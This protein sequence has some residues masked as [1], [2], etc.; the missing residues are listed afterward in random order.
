VY[1]E[2]SQITEDNLLKTV[3]ELSFDLETL[4][5]IRVD[6]DDF[7]RNPTEHKYLKICRK[8]GQMTTKISF[9]GK[10]LDNTIA[11]TIGILEEAIWRYCQ[12]YTIHL[13]EGTGPDKHRYLNDVDMMSSCWSADDEPSREIQIVDCTRDRSQAGTVLDPDYSNAT[14]RGKYHSLE[15]MF[16]R[17]RPEIVAQV[18][19]HNISGR[20]YMREMSIE[21][22]EPKVFKEEFSKMDQWL[23]CIQDL[24]MGAMDRILESYSKNVPDGSVKLRTGPSPNAWINRNKDK[25]V[26]ALSNNNPESQRLLKEFKENSPTSL[27]K[28]SLKYYDQLSE[29][30]NKRWSIPFQ[31]LEFMNSADLNMLI[32]SLYEDG[33]RDQI[34][35]MFYHAI[36]YG[37]YDDD[38]FSL[39]RMTDRKD[40]SKAVDLVKFKY[41]K[42][43]II[44]YLNSIKVGREKEN[45]D[46]EQLEEEMLK[47]EEILAS[48]G[49]HDRYCVDLLSLINN[50]EEGNSRNKYSEHTRNMMETTLNAIS[51][52]KLTEM[53]AGIQRVSAA[54]ACGMKKHKY[55][56]RCGSI[57]G[58]ECVFSVDLIHGRKGMV[59]SNSN[60]TEYEQVD[61]TCFIIGAFKDWD[62]DVVARRGTP[63]RSNWF[64]LSPAQID[65]NVL[66]FH[67]YISYSTM[68]FEKRLVETGSNFVQLGYS[69]MMKSIVVPSLYLTVN[70]SKF[71]QCSEAVRF[72]FV[73]STGI[74]VGTEALYDK[75]DW[76]LPKIETTLEALYFFRMLKMTALTELLS[77][78]GLKSAIMSEY[79]VKSSEELP[80]GMRT[81]KGW[82]IAFPHEKKHNP[83]DQSAFNSMYICKMLTVQR[84]T[85]TMS[86]AQVLR[87]E[88]ENNRKFHDSL[89]LQLDWMM[90]SAKV[91]KTAEMLEAMFESHIPVDGGIY[92]SDVMT[93]AASVIAG[94]FKKMKLKNCDSGTKFRDFVAK[95]FNAHTALRSADIMKLA[96]N[97]GSVSSCG[98]YAISNFKEEV[99]KVGSKT[100]HK[101]HN[102]NSK[103]YQTV[104][105][106][107]YDFQNCS[108]LDGNVSIDD[109]KNKDVGTTEKQGLKP[110][111]LD[112]LSKMST[113]AMPVVI[114][115]LVQQRV[116]VA[117]MVHKDQIGP[118]EI[119]VLNSVL[120]FNAF[121]LEEV[122]RH[123]RTINH[124]MGDYT[125][126]IEYKEKDEVIAAEFDKMRRLRISGERVVNDNADCSQWGP[127]MMPYVLCMT[128]ASR[129]TG[130][131][132]DLV[133]E[134]FK[135]FSF[136]VFKIPDNLKAKI[137]GDMN[138]KGNNEFSKAILE[139]MELDERGGSLPSAS[140]KN[141]IL[142]SFQGMFQGVL[143]N[144]SSEM[145]ADLLCLSSEV[146]FRKLKI[147]VSSFDTSDDYVRI[148]QL[149]GMDE[150]A[151]YKMISQSLW[152]HDFLGKSMGIKRNMYKSN[153][154]E[155]MLEFNSVFRTNRGTF[156][157][158]V[159]SR[160]SFID[161]ST[162]YDWAMSSLRCYTTSVDYLRNE[163]SVIGAIWVQIVN[164]HL[165]LLV[166]GRLNRFRFASEAMFRTPLEL[167]GI[168]RISPVSNS[169]CPQFLVLKQNYDLFGNLDYAES[170][171]VMINSNSRDPEEE[172]E[173]EDDQSLKINS[174]S[175][176]GCVCLPSRYPRAFRS[177]DEFLSQVKEDLYVPLSKFGFRQSMLSA[178]MTCSQRESKVAD[179]PSAAT[180]FCVPQTPDDAKLYKIN[181]V[182]INYLANKAGIEGRNPKVSRNQLLNDIANQYIG[183]FLD[184]PE[185][186]TKGFD[187]TVD[188]D[189]DR[190]TAF[191]N[192]LNHTFNSIR[193]ISE[194]FVVSFINKH[195]M[196]KPYRE[197]FV[198]EFNT[199]STAVNKEKLKY[200]PICFG[201]SSRIKPHRFLSFEIV[202]Q[203][204]L[205][206]LTSVE[207]TFRLCLM[208]KDLS[209]DLSMN[210]IRSNYI[211]GG[212]LEADCD[213]L[214]G[215]S[216]S[217]SRRMIKALDNE[218][219]LFS[220][221]RN[222]K[223][224]MSREVLYK[225]PASRVDVTW[226]FDDIVNNPNFESRVQFVEAVCSLKRN[227]DNRALI[228]NMREPVYS[229]HI[230]DI[231]LPTTVAK[232][233]G[234]SYSGIEYTFGVFDGK[235]AYTLVSKQEF[236]EKGRE[237]WTQYLTHFV[238]NLPI[239]SLDIVKHKTDQV[240]HFKA[241]DKNEISVSIETFNDHYFLCAKSSQEIKPHPILH[242]CY[243]VPSLSQ[244]IRL[245]EGPVEGQRIPLIFRQLPFLPSA[246]SP[247][248]FA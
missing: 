214:Q 76:Y 170:I 136:K 168:V 93:V 186:L 103:G 193:P 143:G 131:Q 230:K 18:V 91:P 228:S 39:T 106:N 92:K 75:L 73:N 219:E 88:M 38:D 179:H 68:I 53:I 33:C 232:Y 114:Y 183:S 204:R 130:F 207:G 138:M 235:V 45:A 159:K 78:N 245:Y 110:D 209:L 236:P 120:R 199:I 248:L 128:I 96:N 150:V 57:T 108:Q 54:V 160:L 237:R 14:I 218:Q 17:G 141:Q 205:R 148:L 31:S 56:N 11:H 238:D 201:G 83:S 234:K 196:K 220:N 72:A 224:I 97:R 36:K 37:H 51:Q 87:K 132:R 105:R 40:K 74:S 153:F 178:L 126:L 176:S 242:L 113:C 175:R 165:D 42:G 65:W 12:G 216:Y 52:I 217:V 115:N 49:E 163:G 244:K 116:C 188:I 225:T 20:D 23:D 95:N 125:N 212:R 229:V 22:H 111:M 34:F 135:Q 156:N 16:L 172:I 223:R 98:E 58:S 134:L 129:L 8:W 227:Q 70:N 4:E 154:T 171:K 190:T 122:A 47:V 50:V 67:K 84:Y 100:I 64:N 109:L 7:G 192:S 86:E 191:V 55:I 101:T 127:S 208:T 174:I 119:A 21:K 1:E 133:I 59:I 26:E 25:I 112:D 35:I 152:L 104:L 166:T 13:I 203:N 233:R 162:D 85:K 66:I 215:P 15:S 46:G 247:V 61:K 60:S 89:D 200:L 77:N 69:F 90:R 210:I 43:K 173:L 240:V 24:D 198:L 41:K 197:E 182:M 102:Q 124:S 80:D 177:I 243:K 155:H 19:S 140:F 195:I 44:D 226:V 169:L 118:R 149:P 231:K 3:T 48:S 144:C 82:L 213:R 30:C 151:V 246:C 139:L 121:A 142:F 180:R 194:D 164:T 184:K 202:L 32:E 221:L 123:I 27:T 187:Y 79:T 71:S 10:D 99:T 2:C 107:Y 239:E 137:D 94:I 189:I 206:K 241:F 9:F 211:E 147:K 145:A 63:W 81:G 146:H 167:G 222:A 157:P 181:S 185:D 161:I 29:S 158:D 28:H 117:K 62:I 5:E 6:F